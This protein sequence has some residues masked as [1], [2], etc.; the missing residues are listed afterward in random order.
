MNILITSAG[1]RGYLVR[2]F[3]EALAG[4]GEVHVGNSSEIAA[5]LAYADRAVVTPLIY[6]PGYIDFLLKYC[7]DNKITAI[8]SLFDVDLY[9]LA[10]NKERF[11]EIGVNVIVSDP[12]VV[13]VCNDKWLT[14]EFCKNNGIKTVDTM[15]SK[16]KV[17]EK[18]K[19]GELNY[20]IIIKP[21]WGM[22]SISILQ[23]NSE[24]EL[25]VLTEMCRRNIRESYL[26]YEAGTDLEHAVIYQPFIDADEYG[27]DI[28]ND[29][30]GNY[31]TTIVRKKIAM[32][33]GETDCA[34]VIKDNHM[35]EVGEKI[36]K[37]LGHIANLDADFLVT[38]DDV[39]LLEMNARF[40]GGYP[41]SHLAGINLPRAIV[42]WLEGKTEGCR[43]L[44]TVKK[45]DR[46]VQK[47]IGFVELSC[48]L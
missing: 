44:L 3:K 16:E 39:Y 35:E 5:A 4:K 37:T 34:V 43:D 47:D 9:M 48:T 10:I 41:F 17:L 8:V 6:A 7:I 25:D 13:S 32:R 19:K 36:G 40:G 33:S 12:E 1:R 28:I 30:E 15:M 23:A 46:I 14:Y 26:K 20:P 11:A 22:G 18:I 31:I 38:E 27:M 2:Y 21:R 45:Y 42:A 29:L 24:V